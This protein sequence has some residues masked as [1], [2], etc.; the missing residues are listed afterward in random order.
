MGVIDVGGLY[1]HEGAVLKH[2]ADVL[3]EQIDQN[4]A[5]VDATHRP[6]HLLRVVRALKT[7]DAHR[8]VLTT[9]LRRVAEKEPSIPAVRAEDVVARFPF[10]RD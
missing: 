10:P 8:R 4:I 3:L 7:P 6:R 1:Y 2:M 5:G 9:A